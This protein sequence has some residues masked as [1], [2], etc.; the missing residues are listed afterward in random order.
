MSTDYHLPKIAMHRELFFVHRQSGTQT[1]RY[2]ECLSKSLTECHDDH[3]SL[4][5]M[6]M[7]R[8]SRR[9]LIIKLPNEYLEDIRNAPMDNSSMKKGRAAPSSTTSPD[10][11]FTW[12]HCTRLYFLRIGLVSHERASRRLGQTGKLSLSKPCHYYNYRSLKSNSQAMKI[13]TAVNVDISP[14]II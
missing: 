14:N 6:D 2:K 8:K 7:D 12:G 5:E 10:D 11:P 9:Q 3:L 13:I 4:S 1:N